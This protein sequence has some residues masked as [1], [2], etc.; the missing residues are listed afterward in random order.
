M[1]Y[2]IGRC[3][4]CGE[5]VAKRDIAVVQLRSGWWRPHFAYVAKSASI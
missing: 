4:K 5:S 2:P 3:P 1:S